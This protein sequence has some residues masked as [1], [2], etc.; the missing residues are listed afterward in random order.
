VARHFA[1]NAGHHPYHMITE[2][3]KGLPPAARAELQR[4]FATRVEAP[5]VALVCEGQAAGELRPLDPDLVV[6]AFLNL[7]LSL[8]EF[9]ADHPQRDA[10][11]GFLVDLLTQGLAARPAG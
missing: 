3:R 2:L 8:G 1:A 9:E 7:M 4:I 5:L 6:R 11:P 10:L